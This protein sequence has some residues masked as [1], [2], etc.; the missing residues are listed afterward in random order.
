MNSNDKAE[1]RRSSRACLECRLAKTKCHVT[2]NQDVCDRCAKFSFECRFV[3]HHRGRKP[4]SKLASIDPDDA[5]RIGGIGSDEE[6]VTDHDSDSANED[7]MNKPDLTAAANDEI[8]ADTDAQASNE[9]AAKRDQ[10][11]VSAATSEGAQRR[12]REV[13]P[14][15]ASGS[16]SHSRARVH[17]SATNLHELDTNARRRIWE[18]L[19][20]K[21]PQRGS[22]YTFVSKGEV[23]HDNLQAST[24]K[25]QGKG[26]AAVAARE[27]RPHHP[28]IA[29]KTRRTRTARPKQQTMQHKVKVQTLHRTHHILRSHPHRHSTLHPPSATFSVLLTRGLA[30]RRRKSRQPLP[31]APLS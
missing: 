20:Q 16:R 17:R 28:M 15:R 23:A 19:A 2:D 13:A 18:M 4:V 7:A 1:K 12:S 3:R 29:K 9:G 30:L 8:A 21:I 25:P 10:D 5:S 26:A 24:S 27:P 14:A 31:S 11:V 22:T 6:M